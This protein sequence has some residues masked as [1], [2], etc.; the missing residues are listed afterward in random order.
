MRAEAEGPRPERSR[1]RSPRVP[2]RRPGAR[3][4]LAAALALVAFAASGA[5]AATPGP[6]DLSAAD[7]LL[8]SELARLRGH[9]AV[10]VRQGGTDIYRF[11]AGDIG[12]DTRVGMASFTKTV[13]AAVVL[14]QRDEGRLELDERLGSALPAFESNGLGAPTLLDAWGMR[15]GL[16]S[17]VPYEHDARFTLAESVDR[18]A[19]FGFLAFAP[20][21]SRLGYDGAGMQA[22]GRIVE[23]RSGAAWEDVARARVL[24]PCGMPGTDF[25]QFAPN[26]SVP[27]GLRSTPEEGIRFARMIL[28]GGVCDGRRVL[29][30]ASVE[31][32]FTNA[33]RGLPVFASPWPATHPLYP[34]GADPDYGFGDW[35]LAESPASGHVEEIVGAGAWG[36]SLWV[37]RRR[38]VAA[39]LYTDVPAGSQDA[40]DATLGL[41]DAVRRAVEARQ[42]RGLTVSGRGPERSL[43]WS[44]A[45]GS[46]ATRLYGS[47]TPIRDLGG[48]RR[49]RL[50]VETPASSAAVP[51]YPYYAATALLGTHENTAL[52]PAVNAL[53]RPVG[54]VRYVPVA[55]RTAGAQGSEWRTDLGLLNPGTTARRATV[56]FHAPAGPVATTI[57]VPPGAQVVRADVVASLGATGSAPLSVAADGELL[58]SS[59]T[60]SPASPCFPGGSIGLALPTFRDGEGLPAGAA[61][62]L[63]QLRED[64]AFRTN[65]S[66]VDLGPA[67]ARVRVG[68]HD[69][70][71]RALG[72]VERTLAPAEWRQLD[73][74]FAPLAA[75]A[76]LAAAWARV[77]VLEG[78][79]VAAFATVIDNA[80][81]DPTVRVAVPE[82]AASSSA[83]VPM[84]S[85]APGAMGAT[86]RTDLGLLNAGPTPRTAT[87]SFLARGGAVSLPFTVPPGTQLVVEDVVAALGAS[88]SAPLAVSA[89]GELVV[90]SRTFSGGG[91]CPGTLGLALPTV[92]DGE[93]LLQGEAAFLPQ[94]REDASSRTNVIV[95]NAAPFSGTARVRF[96]DADGREV[97]STEVKVPASGFVQLDRPFASLGG[98]SD[99]AAGRAL[100]EVVSGGPLVAFA[101]VVDNATNDPVARDASR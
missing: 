20:P 42:V 69:A 99:V 16:D 52:V 18:L 2:R 91:A 60:S 10:I 79:P 31:Q 68:L 22:V 72:A 74:P 36:S 28:D 44:R 12:F 13:S 76:G 78:G 19:R 37:D 84:A 43:S 92:A 63:P 71:G 62:F 27:G 82:S 4:L 6:Y 53:D 49:A 23:L 73:R 9:V 54:L 88:G 55:S 80:T 70:S 14:S 85:H 8:R 48:L 98:R 77:E 1:S 64:P 47:A 46:S 96:H 81:N 95:V 66:L 61:G 34:Y 45:D 41:F 100:V 30:A 38:G 90:S 24:E 29:S 56:T 67:P 21:G 3:D 51:A 15:S 39:V 97:A 35:V 94:L 83:L 87:V 26:P 5:N 33:T 40:L 93:G 75:P 25:G 58:V 57:D 17:L 32:L 101:T 7:A 59:R 11:Q 86:W 65:V 50:L 89:D